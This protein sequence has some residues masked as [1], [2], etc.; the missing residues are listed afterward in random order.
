MQRNE[1]RKISKKQKLKLFRQEALANEL[2]EQK[3]VAK[4]AS[5][6]SGPTVKSNIQYEKE[7][8]GWK[9]VKPEDLLDV[10]IGSLMSG[11][12]RLIF[13]IKLDDGGIIYV[14][15]HSSDADELRRKY[16][17]QKIVVCLTQLAGLLNRDVQSNDWFNSE[18]FGK[19]AMV[20]SLAGGKVIDNKPLK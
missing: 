8:D 15:S 18:M 12:T 2:Y 11:K 20:C 17:G 1:K 16:E 3:K 10:S 6:F 9:F 19:I 13:E 5:E 7:T 14:T 4:N